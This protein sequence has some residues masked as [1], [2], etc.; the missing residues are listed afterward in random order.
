MPASL[1]DGHVGRGVP[2]VAANSSGNSGYPLTV[3]ALVATPANGT[4][5]SAPLWA[6]LIARLN[7]ALG[8]DLGFVNPVAVRL[9]SG[10]FRDIVAHPGAAD[11][12][13]G[14]TRAIRSGTRWMRHRVGQ[15]AARALL[16][17]LRHF[18]GPAIAVSLQDD[19]QF[20]TVCAARST[21]P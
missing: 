9:G 14:S 13:F 19:L 12:G 10:V 6:G 5:A 17:G 20:G 3:T 1:N 16:T 18:Y 4:S 15:P 8:E 11:N 2:D 7:T 21:G